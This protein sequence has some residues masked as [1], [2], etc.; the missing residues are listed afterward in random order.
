MSVPSAQR[1]KH[2]SE[3]QTLNLS[4]PLCKVTRTERRSLLAVSMLGVAIASTGLIPTRISAL[5][6]E[7]ERADQR[8]FLLLLACVVLYFIMTF[9]IYATTDL[10][11]WRAA[12][13]HALLLHLREE[14][15][16]VLKQDSTEDNA[17]QRAWNRIERRNWRWASWARHTSKLRAVWEFGLPIA[18]GCYAVAIL[19]W[20]RHKI[21]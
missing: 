16:V 1:P 15:A 12:Y 8:G 7:F 19:F 11:A 14:H 5:G 6:I 10:I 3:L 18:F 21:A 4:D 20:A 13:D 9:S 2:L 17:R